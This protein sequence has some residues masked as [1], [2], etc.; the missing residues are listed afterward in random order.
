MPPNGTA[1]NPLRN[2]ATSANPRGPVVKDVAKA[3][4]FAAVNY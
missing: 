1:D 2:G 3:V 4:S